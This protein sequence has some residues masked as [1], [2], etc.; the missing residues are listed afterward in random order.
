MRDSS[1]HRAKFCGQAW[2]FLIWNVYPDFNSK[3]KCLRT[4]QVY[5]KGNKQIWKNKH[6]EHFTRASSTGVHLAFW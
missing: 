1:Q 5:P 2:A 4:K 6:Q 3:S